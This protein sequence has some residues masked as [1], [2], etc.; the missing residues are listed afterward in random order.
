MDRLCYFGMWC[1][2]KFFLLKRHLSRNL[3]DVADWE[4]QILGMEGAELKKK[5]KGGKAL[6]EM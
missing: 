6:R 5:L 2:S 1:S 3:K 4:K